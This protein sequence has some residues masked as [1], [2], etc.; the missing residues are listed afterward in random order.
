M[1]I[2]LDH[3]ALLVRSVEDTAAHLERAFGLVPNAAKSFEREGTREVY[4]GPADAS[5]RVLLIEPAHIDGPYARA[6]SRRGPCLHHVAFVVPNL[7]AFVAGLSGSGWFLHPI[8]LESA[9]QQRTVWLVRPGVECL[10]EIVETTDPAEKP[11][12]EVESVA[13]PTRPET[14]TAIENL[15]TLGLGGVSASDDPKGQITLGGRTLTIP[16]LLGPSG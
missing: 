2:P 13:V 6:L 9:E 11:N 14:R 1:T 16:E 3:V 5:G 4:L 10:V 15:R 12:R 8:S 7:R